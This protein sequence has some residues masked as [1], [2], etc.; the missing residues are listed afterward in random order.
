MK[1]IEKKDTPDVSGGWRP[2]DGGC[3]PIVPIIPLPG[4]PLIPMPGEGIEY[5]KTPAGPY[6]TDP[7][8]V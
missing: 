1:E 7:P 5:P 2:D 4:G 6:I 3:I 8:A